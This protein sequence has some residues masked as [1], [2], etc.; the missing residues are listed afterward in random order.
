MSLVIILSVQEL[1]GYGFLLCFQIKPLTLKRPIAQML[2]NLVWFPVK[3]HH[4]HTVSV[5]HQLKW[6]F[7]SVVPPAVYVINVFIM[8]QLL[9]FFNKST[10]RNR[11]AGRTSRYKCKHPC[12]YLLLLF[13]K[14][15]CNTLLLWS[16][17]IVFWTLSAPKYFH[18]HVS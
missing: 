7:L 18:Y 5:Q 2:Q 13:L 1:N 15:S 8:M 16:T 10:K 6:L 11:E 14:L 17:V 12:T 3:S 4:P 9:L